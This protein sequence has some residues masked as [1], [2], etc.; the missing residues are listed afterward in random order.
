LYYLVRM[1]PFTT[2]SKTMQGGKLDCAD[3]LF[4]SVAEC[5]DSCLNA[6]SDVK[7][8]IPE[9]YYAPEFLLNRNNVCLGKKQNGEV[10]SDVKL[11]PWANGS[12]VTFV[13]IMRQGLESEYVSE[14]LHHW[15]DLVFGY[16]Q[17]L[18][19]ARKCHNLFHPYTYEGNVDIDAIE[20]ATEK[21][22][23]LAQI[24]SF[25]QTPTQLFVKP[26]SKRNSIDSSSISAITTTTTTTAATTTATTA[27]AATTSAVTKTVGK[28]TEANNITPIPATT[29]AT[30]TNEEENKSDGVLKKGWMRMEEMND[31]GKQV[32]FK[33]L[34]TLHSDLTLRYNVTLKEKKME[35]KSI[36]LQEFLSLRMIGAY[37]FE[38][39]TKS[40]LWKFE[41]NQTEDRE[42][43]IKY[44]KSI[45][46]M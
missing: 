3:R 35:K 32:W 33:R 25:G 45:S 43:W 12:A 19:E 39:I 37:G 46:L 29:T 11:P 1:E 4:D 36:S 8:L 30:T 23:I 38:V 41:C 16:K 13:E 40:K 17:R 34:F 9:F 31:T 14:N 10:L 42:E 6:T 24:D 2:C 18:P 26:H 28:D 15:I 27:T 44:I 22:A 21:R 5:F 20:D 7:E